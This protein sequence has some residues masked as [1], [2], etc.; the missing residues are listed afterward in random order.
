MRL[1]ELF[2]WPESLLRWRFEDGRWRFIAGAGIPPSLHGE[3][4]SAD[5]TSDVL[6]EARRSRRDRNLH[7]PIRIGNDSIDLASQLSVLGH[8]AVVLT[9]LPS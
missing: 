8:S 3:V 6:S 2:G 5:R 9:V 7:I 4:R 1:K